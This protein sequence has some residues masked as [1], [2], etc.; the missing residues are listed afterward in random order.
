[1][2]LLMDD[3]IQQVKQLYNGPQPDSETLAELRQLIRNQGVKQNLNTSLSEARFVVLDTEATGFEA[4]N[5][6]EIIS[7]GAVVVQGG[8][9][10][11][12]ESLNLF[13]DPHRSIPEAIT[14]LTGIKDDMVQGCMSIYEATREYLKLL[15]N[16]VIA[17]HALGFDLGFLNYKLSLFGV[18]KIQNCIWDTK[19]VARILHPTLHE[20][21]LDHMLQ[22][23][24]IEP[25]DRHRALG[26]CLLTAKVMLNQISLLHERYVNTLKQL[27]EY[28]KQGGFYNACH[29]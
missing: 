22:L 17:G 8:Q 12:E 3:S 2:F 23:Y 5:G 28:R 1:M 25:V 7:L 19:T 11:T 13:V 18:G 9:I 15:G 16:S 29:F 20:Y 21:S 26:D 6:D 10:Y 4:D 14:E 27:Y 24:G